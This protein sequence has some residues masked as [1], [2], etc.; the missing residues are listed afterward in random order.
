MPHFYRDNAPS[1]VRAAVFADDIINAE[2]L[3]L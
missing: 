2:N 1:G 3:A